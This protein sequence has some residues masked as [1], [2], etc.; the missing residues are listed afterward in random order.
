M[1]ADTDGKRL[2]VAALGNNTI[3]VLDFQAGKHLAS[4]GGLHEPQGVAFVPALSRIFVA[5]GGDGKCRVFDGTTLKPSAEMDFS[6]DADNVRYDQSAGVIYVGYGDGALGTAS[7]REAK[8]GESI[9]LASHPES[10]QL[11]QSGPR[12]FVNVPNAGHVAVI[13]RVQRTVTARWPIT[14]AAANFPMAL[15]EA[16]RRLFIGCRKPARV[17]VFDTGSGKMTTEFPCVQ[18]TDDLFYDGGRKRLYVSGGQGALEAFG[19]TS[20][21][22]FTLLKRIQ[23]AP[24]A[25]TS[26][27]VP[28]LDRLFLAVPH[29][30]AQ[31]AEIRVYVAE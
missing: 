14:S 27:F 19:Q 6:S 11:E 20:D 23:T 8:V 2:F 17:L 5:N 26:L 21:G 22:R 12:I 3:E 7:A 28:A 10:F 4:V 25:R 30:G 9:K 18:D 24:G 16:R 29:R 1:A 31:R 15:D 13:D